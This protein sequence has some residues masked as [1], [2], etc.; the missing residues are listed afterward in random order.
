MDRPTLRQLEIFI[1]VA[2]VGTFRGAARN[3]GLSQVAISDHIRQLEARLGAPLFERVTGGKP[4]LAPAGAQV[5]DHARNVL[6]ACDALVD[7]AR[8][9]GGAADLPAGAEPEP[10]ASKPVAARKA[11]RERT[12]APASHAPE[13]AMPPA[14]VD[15]AAVLA[16]KV[17]EQAPLAARAPAAEAEPVER[18]PVEAASESPIT[19]ATHPAILSRLQDRLTAAE[20]AFPERPIAVDYRCFTLADTLAG[21]K[22]ARADIFVFYALSDPRDAASRYLWSEPWSLFV[23][24]DHPLARADM[25]SRRD[26]VDMP[27][28]ML[29]PANPLRP[30][31]EEALGQAGLW[32]APTVLETDDLSR[33]AQELDF[34]ESMFAAFGVTAA[35]LGTRQGLRRLALAE[36]LPPVQ[37]RLAVS[38]PAEEDPTIGALVMLL[39]LGSGA[40][41][42]ST[43]ATN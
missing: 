7:A 6:F 33:V 26:C 40:G 30:L 23:R 4:R 5:I 10:V 41:G 20:E 3:L 37:I 27:V 43:G 8:A 16:E 42:S 28:I 14:P 11:K 1:E 18:P 17:V 36:P 38:P 24:A 25:L 35:Q 39:A 2:R 31:Y 12:P 9:A 32:P 15:F 19:V 34:G 13:A 29:D 21:L 22:S